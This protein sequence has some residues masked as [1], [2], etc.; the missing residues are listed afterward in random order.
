MVQFG[1]NL[2]RGLVFGLP[3]KGWLGGKTHAPEQSNGGEREHR[4]RNKKTH[5]VSDIRRWQATWAD[6]LRG[7]GGSAYFTSFLLLLP[8]GN[9][10]TSAM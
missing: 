9:I 6:A 10:L 3:G 4:K 2:G 5:M 1:F 8:A 7:C